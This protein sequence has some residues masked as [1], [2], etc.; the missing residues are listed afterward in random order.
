M[1]ITQ[2]YELV[3]DLY[4]EFVGSEEVKTAD[5]TNVVDMGKEVVDATDVEP[6][7]KTIASKVGKT[8][9]VDRPYESRAPRIQKDAYEFGSILEKIDSDIPEAIQ[10]ESAMLQDGTSYDNQIYTASK[11]HSKYFTDKDTFQIPLSKQDKYIKGAFTSETKLAGFFSMLESGVQKGKGVRMDQ[12]IKSTIATAIGEIIKNGKETQKIHLLSEYNT[13]HG[14][15]LTAEQALKDESFLRDLSVKYKLTAGR[16]GELNVVYNEGGRP[17][18]TPKGK[19]HA[20]MLDEVA[21]KLEAY[22]YNANGQFGN[23]YLKVEDIDT[24]SFWQGGAEG[25]YKWADI[26]KIDVKLPESGEVVTQS[27]VVGILFDDE[28]IVVSNEDDRVTSFYNAAAEFVNLWY[29]F[30]AS[31]LIDTNEQIVV[32]VLD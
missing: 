9:F 26:S 19:L 6:L 1:K 2:V 8:K 23:E 15:T 32:F 18:Q 31:Y 20:V 13:E 24:C 3:N 30:D 7:Y 10:N 11:V 29:K 25:G 5:M 28:A 14:T 17:R 12:L 4:K 22:L 21:R 16:M 27:N